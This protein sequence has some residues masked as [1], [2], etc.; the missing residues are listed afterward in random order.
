MVFGCSAL[1]L[2]G[3]LGGD[4][5]PERFDQKQ[6]TVVPDGPD[7]LRIREVVDMDFGRAARHGY[8]RVVPV[9]FG[10][11]S[12]VTARSDTA[13]DDVGVSW[14]GRGDSGCDQDLCVRMRIGSPAV[15]ITG[16]HRYELAYTLPQARMSTGRL[17]LDVIGTAEALETGRFEIVVAGMT[18]AEPQCHTGRDG[19]RGGC[20][21]ERDGAV[22]RAVVSPLAPGAGITIAG[23][24]TGTGAA[25]AVAVPELP[26]RHPDHRTPLAGIVAAVGL[27]GGTGTYW[28]YR[29]LGRNELPAVMQGSTLVPDSRLPELAGIAYRPPDDLQPWEG[30]ALLR[31][32]VDDVTV[33]AWFSGHVAQE[34]IT[35]E[36]AGKTLV[37]RRGPRFA[38]VTGRPAKR[39]AE[40]FGDKDQIRISGYSSGFASTWAAIKRDQLKRVADSGWW[41]GAPPG[42]MR[43]SRGSGWLLFGLLLVGVL[44]LGSLGGLLRGLLPGPVAAVSL[45]LAVPVIAARVAY[46]RLLPSRSASGTELTLE[47]EAFRKFLEAAEAQQVEWAWQQGMVRT[48]SAWAVA[49]DVAD[50]WR[51]ALTQANVPQ[52]EAALVSSPLL[53]SEMASTLHTARVAPASSSS[54]SSSSS[55][56]SSSFSGGSVGGGGGGGSSGSW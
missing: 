36:G 11:P 46:R 1:V 15:T 21:L 20:T 13:P 2:A 38:E 9:D 43:R 12:G 41:R 52:A 4:V 51:S 40:L 30:A 37:I 48:F 19:D 32:R 34:A 31:E 33:A 10:E 3:F 44:G 25:D 55:S 24:V 56:G 47:V 39:L 8:Q 29:Q 35:L 17:A 26:A 54:G 28:R 50:A 53:L 49:L 7:G 45:G 27:L 18:L 23:R 22:Y 5:R 14:V 6:V 16:Q 42:S